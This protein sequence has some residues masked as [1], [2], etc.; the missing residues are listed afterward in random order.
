MKTTFVSLC[1]V[2]LAMSAI[3]ASNIPHAKSGVIPIGGET[4]WDYLAIEK[5]HNR[6]YV[7]HGSSV[8]I[9]DLTRNVVIGGILDQH[10][11]H[12]IAFAPE[13]NRGFIT[14][15]GDHSVTLFDLTTMKQTGKIIIPGKKPDAIVYDPFT[16]RMFSFNGGSNNATAIDAKSGTVVGNVELDGAPE[17]GASDNIGLM[18]VNLED[19]NMV[20]VFDP[21][22]LKVVAKW[23]LTPCE[24][25]TGMAMDVKHNLLFVGGHNKLMAVLD[26]KSG[27][28]IKTLPIGEGVDACAFDD[29]S[30]CAFASCGKSGVVTV[31][32]EESPT[33]FS[34]LDNIA[35]LPKARTMALD[36]ETHKIYLSTMIDRPAGVAPDASQ[37]STMFGVVIVQ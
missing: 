33:S 37:S 18:F 15:G 22:A 26:V 10:G 6:L 28:V 13:F 35:T 32:K 4:R 20:E 5:T 7:S 25:P 27:Q 12:G 11:V 14:N 21:K 30:Q 1:L 16:K 34:V 17:F 36:A 2:M 3:A 8:D 31:V 24:S 29:A 9:I 19:A 23:P